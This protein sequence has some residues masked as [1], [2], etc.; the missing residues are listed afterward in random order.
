M[1]V[2][3]EQAAANRERVLDV[4][5]KLFR[6]R[7]FSGVGVAELMKGAGLTHG[8]FYGQ[9]ESK[10]DLMAQAVTRGFDVSRT[11]WAKLAA[12]SPNEPLA[13]IAGAYL[14]TAHRDHPGDGCVIAALGAEAAREAGPVR[15]AIT[16]GVRGLVDQLLQWMPGKSAAARRKRAL[17][18]FAG[19]VGALVLSRTVDDPALSQEILQAVQADLGFGAGSAG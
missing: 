9:F 17:A 14:S 16:D 10:D 4:A 6:E 18:T 19:F 11:H 12:R 5:A 13:A 15:R 7:G 3:R 8:G 2:T 1:K